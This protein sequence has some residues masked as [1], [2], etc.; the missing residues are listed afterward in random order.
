MTSSLI[1]G[2][3]QVG[4]APNENEVTYRFSEDLPD[5][6]YRIEV[7]GLMIHLVGS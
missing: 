3:I 2:A 5:D 6:L 4:A 7:F 1:P